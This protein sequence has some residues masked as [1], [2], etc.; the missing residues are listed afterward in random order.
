MVRV[1]DPN[2]EPSVAGMLKQE[3]ARNSTVVAVH[4]HSRYGLVS[5]P[6]GVFCLH[7]EGV[8]AGRPINKM[9]APIQF[10]RKYAES[11]DHIKFDKEPFAT[12]IYSVAE[13]EACLTGEELR[14]DEFIAARSDRHERNLASWE[15]ILG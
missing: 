1:F 13:C 11:S 4:A 7:D 3:Q 5:T 15:R 9:G 6:K 14:L 12:A 2:R 10:Y 8:G